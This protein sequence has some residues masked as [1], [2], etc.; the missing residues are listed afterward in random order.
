MLIRP[1]IHSVLLIGLAAAAFAQDSNGGSDRPMVQVVV[2][3]ASV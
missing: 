3:R 1:L 2:W